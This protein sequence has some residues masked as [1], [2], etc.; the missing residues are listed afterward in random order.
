MCESAA[1]YVELYIGN[2]DAAMLSP[3]LLRMLS[4]NMMSC[5][6]VTLIRQTMMNS[7]VLTMTL[8]VMLSC[9]STTLILTS[10]LSYQ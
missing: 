4:L 5:V 8:L 7:R 2:Y 10:L 1:D 9:M 6:S 3:L